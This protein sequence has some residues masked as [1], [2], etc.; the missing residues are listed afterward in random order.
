MTDTPH[1]NHRRRPSP[2]WLALDV[3]A[4]LAALASGFYLG[5][6]DN[7]MSY[8][9]WGLLLIAVSGAALRRWPRLGKALWYGGCFAML[10]L[11]LLAG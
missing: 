8:V 7:R 5:R 10:A 4:I 9:W 2:A 6:L 1:A 3:A 11:A